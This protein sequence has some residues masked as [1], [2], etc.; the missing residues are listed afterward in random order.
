[1][2]SLLDYLVYLGKILTAH[3]SKPRSSARGKQQ[4]KA[5]SKLPC[6]FFSSF[7]L[8]FFPPYFF[9][10]EYIKKS[11]SDREKQRALENKVNHCGRTPGVDKWRKWLLAQHQLFVFLVGSFSSFALHFCLSFS[12]FLCLISQLS[13]SYVSL[14]PD[15]NHPSFTLGCSYCLYS[16]PPFLLIFFLAFSRADRIV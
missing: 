13:P 3:C 2:V 4:W 1:M 6:V 16:A 14:S 11:C 8:L 7:F 12:P 9:P 5:T 15:Q 10:T